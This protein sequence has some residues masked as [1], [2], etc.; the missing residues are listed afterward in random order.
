MFLVFPSDSSRI[1]YA[2]HRTRRFNPTSANR[3]EAQIVARPRHTY[4]A[5]EEADKTGALA[6]V[7]TSAEVGELDKTRERQQRLL[8][9]DGREQTFQRVGHGSQNADADQVGACRRVRD[10]SDAEEETEPRRVEGWQDYDD[11]RSRD[12]EGSGGHGVRRYKNGARHGSERGPA[13]GNGRGGR[14]RQEGAR[15]G[16]H[17]H[18]AAADTARRWD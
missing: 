7:S 11:G 10:A 9:H 13:V 14:E 4:H 16:Q 2:G 18:D 1:E 17:R 8:S 6:T 12:K 3:T 15:L 5:G